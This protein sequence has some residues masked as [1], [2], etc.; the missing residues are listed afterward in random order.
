MYQEGL[1][2]SLLPGYSG[3]R[4]RVVSSFFLSFCGIWDVKK[5]S[6]S[7][8]LARFWHAVGIKMNRAS[9]KNWSLELHSY[10]ILGPQIWS[11]SNSSSRQGG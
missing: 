11:S 9:R 8:N 4:L 2:G 5:E 7:C 1:R 3:Y 6:V 10:E